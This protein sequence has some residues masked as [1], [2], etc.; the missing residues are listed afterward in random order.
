MFFRDPERLGYLGD[1]WR[2]EG[3]N[4]GL[5][6]VLPGHRRWAFPGASLTPHLCATPGPIGLCVSLSHL[7]SGQ[8]SF[9][10]SKTTLV[11]VA[12]SVRVQ[13]ERYTVGTDC[14]ELARDLA[15]AS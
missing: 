12:V 10:S 15:V 1:L 9:A 13:L 4:A 3:R 5:L 6:L 11:S 7:K 8:V 14:K 2:G